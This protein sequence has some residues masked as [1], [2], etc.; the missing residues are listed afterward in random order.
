MIFVFYTPKDP[1]SNPIKNF[2]VGGIPLSPLDLDYLLIKRVAKSGVLNKSELLLSAHH[3]NII[4]HNSIFLK[5]VW[6]YA[7]KQDLVCISMFS[8]SYVQKGQNPK[9]K[10]YENLPNAAATYAVGGMATHWTA[11]TPRENGEGE[12]PERS[13]LF[14]DEEWKSMYSEAEF[15]L[16]THSDVFDDSLRQQAILKALQPDFPEVRP[17]PLGVERVKN[18][19][20]FLVKWTGADNV[21]GENNIQLLNVPD[22]RFSIKVRK[23]VTKYISITVVSKFLSLNSI[24][25]HSL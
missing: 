1:S 21:L 4:Y 19:C 9:Q 15:L 24:C 2:L 20:T 18:D 22:S 7:T 11:C 23:C 12:R 17:L 8:Y 10:P 5:L 3:N 6:N 25:I 13:N 14:G 16:N